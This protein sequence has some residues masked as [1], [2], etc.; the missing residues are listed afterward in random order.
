MPEEFKPGCARPMS[1]TSDT[2]A[3]PIV[4]EDHLYINIYG[5]FHE[6]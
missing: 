4:T 2:D 3:K 5:R 1:E 6:D